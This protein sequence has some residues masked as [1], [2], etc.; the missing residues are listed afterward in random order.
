[1][2]TAYR[3][4]IAILAEPGNRHAPVV[5]AA[6]ERDAAA[7]LIPATIEAIFVSVFSDGR[8]AMAYRYRPAA[9]ARVRGEYQ[10]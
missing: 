9:L 4:H 7:G 8:F 6:V 5:L 2:S 10:N 1:M 3:P